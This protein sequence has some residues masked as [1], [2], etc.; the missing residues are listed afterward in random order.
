MSLTKSE[1]DVVRSRVH[2][3]FLLPRSNYLCMKINQICNIEILLDVL[4]FDGCYGQLKKPSIIM[5][6]FNSSICK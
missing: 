6:E 5:R 4:R 2:S 1:G 3:Y